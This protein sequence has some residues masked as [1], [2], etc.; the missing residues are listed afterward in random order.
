M[1]MSMRKL[2]STQKNQTNNKYP[3]SNDDIRLLKQMEIKI[4]TIPTV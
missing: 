4:V 2:N 3:I 1:Q